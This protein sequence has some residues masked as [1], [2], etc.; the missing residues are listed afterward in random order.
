VPQLLSFV[1]RSTH[2]VPHAVRPVSQAIV[3]R[4]LEQTCPVGHAP[5][6]RPQFFAS[7]CRSAQSPPGHSVCPVLQPQAPPAQVRPAPQTRPQAP[8]L[9][10]SSAT[11]THVAAAPDPHWVAPCGHMP[12]FGFGAAS[13][14]DEPASFF[15]C[16]PPSPPVLVGASAVTGASTAEPPPLLSRLTAASAPGVVAGTRASVV[17]P[18]LFDPHEAAANPAN[19]NP[20]TKRREHRRSLVMRRPHSGAQALS[21]PPTIAVR[22]EMRMLD[23]VG[24]GWTITGKRPTLTL[25]RACRLMDVL[26]SW[27]RP[28]VLART[29]GVDGR[30]KIARRRSDSRAA[31]RRLG[32]CSERAYRPAVDQPNI[33][34]SGLVPYFELPYEPMSRPNAFARPSNRRLCGWGEAV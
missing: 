6:Q 15:A 14:A 4:P 21:P 17:S 1:F 26:R 5:P 20:N 3:Q 22:H 27:F 32:R 12:M 30:L 18:S 29:D 34:G 24:R 33:S 2:E 23:S 7:V 19:T 9:F 28:G 25:V 13:P 10:S 8:Q 11:F 31:A 16:P